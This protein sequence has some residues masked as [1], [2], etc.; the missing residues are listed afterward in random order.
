MVA[1][2]FNNGAGNRDNHMG[3]SATSFSLMDPLVRRSE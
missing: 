1:H 2:C 3:L